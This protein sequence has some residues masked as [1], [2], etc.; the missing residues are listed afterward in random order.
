MEISA[1]QD[2]IFVWELGELLQSTMGCTGLS[3]LALT[4]MWVVDEDTIDLVGDDGETH[5]PKGVRPSEVL[6]TLESFNS[7]EE[8]VLEFQSKSLPLEGNFLSDLLGAPG[9]SAPTIVPRLKKFTFSG[10]LLHTDLAVLAPSTPPPPHPRAFK[11]VFPSPPPT[12]TSTLQ[13][14]SAPSTVP[15]PAHFHESLLSALEFRTDPLSVADGRLKA[16]LETFELRTDSEEYLLALG[17]LG[18]GGE[19]VAQMVSRSGRRLGLEAVS[20]WQE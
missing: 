18:G 15:S 14:A 20:T 7:L 6:G 9:P 19:V 2:E 12:S 11:S 16:T 8:L 4:D 3:R 13:N 1:P 17:E 5:T 10:P